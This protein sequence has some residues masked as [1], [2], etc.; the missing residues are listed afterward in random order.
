MACS[1]KLLDA[2]AEEFESIVNYLLA[3]SD[4]PSA[5]LSF[6]DEFE[7]KMGLICDNPFLYGPSRM[8][9][10]SALGYRAALINSYIALYFYRDGAVFVAH[11][12]HQRQDYARLV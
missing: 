1:Y 12:F 11:I 4:G 7:R 2:A 6:V 5:A 8:P 10:L 9:E 3:I